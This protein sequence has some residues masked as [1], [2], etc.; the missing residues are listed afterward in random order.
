M[1]PTTSIFILM[2]NRADAPKQF[3]TLQDTSFIADLL[4]KI[5]TQQLFCLS[6]VFSIN[7]DIKKHTSDQQVV[8]F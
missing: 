8:A 3:I 7:K 2:L 4:T 6:S 1:L 5:L